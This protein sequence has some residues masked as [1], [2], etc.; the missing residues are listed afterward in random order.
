MVILG[1]TFKITELYYTYF[2]VCTSYVLCLF[3]LVV[4]FL[5]TNGALKNF[6]NFIVFTTYMLY[7][8]D[9]VVFFLL[10]AP[11]KNLNNNSDKI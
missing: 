9:L 8:F 10:L 11:L 2:I 7:S 1:Q 5:L 4:R 3:N 6:Y